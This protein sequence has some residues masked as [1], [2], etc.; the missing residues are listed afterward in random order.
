M[1]MDNPTAAQQR[2]QIRPVK[3]SVEDELI[4]RPGVVGVDID[5]KET[6]GEKTGE[7][8]I[9]VFVQEKKPRS[10][11]AKGTAVPAEIDGVK[12]DVRELVIELQ[13]VM[14]QVDG[15][16]SVD[17]ADYPTLAGGMSIGPRR[18][19]FLA[20]PDAPA[21]G[22]Y[23][24]VGTLGAMV[25]DRATGATM[26]LTNF[27]VACLDTTWSVG[28]RQ[29][30]PSLVDDSSGAD[31]G[32]LTRGVLSENVDGAVITVDPGQAWTPSVTGVGD[33]AGS[34]TATV[35]MAVQKRGRTTEHTFGTVV[36]TDFTVQV[37]YRGIGDRTFRRQLR[38]DPDTSQNARFSNGGDSG[39]VIL[40]SSR[41]V[42]GLLFAGAVDGSMTFANP[43][44][45]ALDELGVDLLLPMPPRLT[46]PVVVCF[47]TRLSIC[48]T[49]RDCVPV[50]RVP[51]LCLTR[52]VVCEQ[53]SRPQICD[54]RTR[55]VVCPPTKSLACPT[56][57]FLCEI[58]VTRPICTI[59][60][61]ACGGE[62]EWPGGGLGGGVGPYG[63]SGADVASVA[64]EAWWSG[65]L[66]ALEEVDV[67]DEGDDP[68]DGPV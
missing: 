56:K 61:R 11:L 20:P 44:Q 36:S 7:M 41:N 67:L 38:I 22:S 34:A 15:E 13:P 27:H 43:V 60:T 30:Q 51:K 42:V 31:F 10:R 64:D 59:P 25:S 24:F 58:E 68:T 3:E 17:A 46:R 45:A 49:S 23:V 16:P 9:V 63:G 12:T 50:T 48:L 21:P 40:D 57:P 4:A 1:S 5:E 62:L 47:D 18:S 14:R 37:P 33:V 66:A 32:S 53:L 52:P 29:V 19:L 35:G 28:D 54:L 26:A 39:S 65:Y 6:G 8:S 55:P 2:A